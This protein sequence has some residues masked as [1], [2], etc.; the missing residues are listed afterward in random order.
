[1][2]TTS[3]LGPPGHLS[4][5]L[6]TKGRDPVGKIVLL[7][8]VAGETLPH[9][10]VPPA[11]RASLRTERG[12]HPAPGHYGAM[13]DTASA[14][15]DRLRSFVET[16]LGDGRFARVATSAVHRYADALGLS[17]GW[18]GPLF[19]ACW[20]EQATIDVEREGV[21]LGGSLS[22]QMLVVTLERDCRF[23]FA[24]EA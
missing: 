2:I 10:V 17:R 8:F 3:H 16:F 23:N 18:L 19:M 21:Q 9:F 5:L 14:T 6:L 1:M 11:R 4:F 12:D 7:T 24:E 15:A 20:L 13:M 22:W